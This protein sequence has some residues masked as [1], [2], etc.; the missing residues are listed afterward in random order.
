M[1]VCVSVLS[2]VWVMQWRVGSAISSALPKLH[3]SSHSG[4]APRVPQNRMIFQPFL[5]ALLI[6]VWKVAC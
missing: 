1:W 2:L 3:S 6:E 4:V 5:I